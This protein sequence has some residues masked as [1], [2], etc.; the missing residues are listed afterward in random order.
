MEQ[1]ILT[2][3]QWNAMRTHVISCAPLEACGLLAGTKN[4]VTDVLPIANDAASPTQFR[5]E[6]AEQLR[7]F[8]WIET[9]RLDLVGIYHSHPK[10]PENPSVTDIAEAAYAV[11][12]V[13]WS[14]AG[15]EWHARGYCI[16]NSQTSD[17]ELRIEEDPEPLH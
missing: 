12:H 4:L 14:P 2:P 6:P 13:I 11:V 5:M 7:T 17:V 1:L 9:N 15:V 3:N 16:V 8:A 10:G